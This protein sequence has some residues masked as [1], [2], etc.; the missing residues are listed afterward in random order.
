M[1]RCLMFVACALVGLGV[2]AEPLSAQ[3]RVAIARPA[4]T[5]A[6][7]DTAPPPATSRISA[8]RAMTPRLPFRA[9]SV[10]SYVLSRLDDNVN[11]DTIGAT[12]VGMIS[13]LTGRFE[14]GPVRP[15]LT[16]E[17]DV[18]LHRYSAT[19]RFNRLSQRGR[20]IIAARVRRW[21]TVDLIT[22]GTLKGSSEDRDVAD[23]LL[24][25][26]RAEFRLGGARRL[27]LVG[28][29][30]LRRFPTDTAQNARNRYV[31]AEFR[32]RFAEGGDFEAEARVEKNDAIG[33]RFD[34]DR[35]TYTT[36][37]VTPLG[38]RAILHVELQYR[39]QSYSG[40]FVEIRDRDYPRR[41][42]R[43]Q[44]AAALRYQLHPFTLEMSYEP[45]WRLSN[46]PTRSID[47]QVLLFGLRHRW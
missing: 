46:D 30:R 38:E 47:Q 21:W 20:S 18:A 11:R 25:Q 45:E 36:G 14:S 27:R 7:P 43:L 6:R 42:H 3:K 13:G 5:P 19:T 40:R 37:Y 31:A 16:L 1:R 8:Q 10:S 17:Y 4:S 9:V 12:S 32:H 24:V 26:P 33:S 44:P 15:W 23:Q 34:Y 39:I 2:C 22:E 35:S 29:Q 28:S 41:D